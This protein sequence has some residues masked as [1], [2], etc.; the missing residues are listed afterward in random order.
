MEMNPVVATREPSTDRTLRRHPR[1]LFSVPITVRRPTADGAGS[2]RGISLDIS[3]GGIAALV[4]ENLMVGEAVE[5]EFPL[6]ETGLRL[7]AVV[8]HSCSVRS[9]FEFLGLTSEERMQI[10]N[11]F[12]STDESLG[13][14]RLMNWLMAPQMSD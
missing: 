1:A 5:I 13:S 12:H 6:R 7:V 10:A 11:T 3:E 8:R 14:L 4:Q 2:S 9:G